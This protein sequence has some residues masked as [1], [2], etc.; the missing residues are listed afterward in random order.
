MYGAVGERTASYPK[1]T[2]LYITWGGPLKRFLRVWF[3]FHDHFLPQFQGSPEC[4]FNF[5]GTLGGTSRYV[6]RLD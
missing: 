6:A 3:V 1:R 5:M 4:D 2:F